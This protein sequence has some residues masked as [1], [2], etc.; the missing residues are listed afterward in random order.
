MNKLEK[1]IC[2]AREKGYGDNQIKE[3]L[4]KHNWPKKEIETAFAYLSKKYIHK[5]QITLFLSPEVLSKL[6]K[7]ADK[8]SFTLTEQIE[9]ILRRSTLTNKKSSQTEKLEDKFI[10]YFSRKK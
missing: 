2:E 10:S 3:I 7:R 9:D 4:L 1:F 5:N 8:N 6:Q